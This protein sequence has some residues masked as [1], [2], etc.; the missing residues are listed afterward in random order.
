M[1]RSCGSASLI[2]SNE[3]SIKLTLTAGYFISRRQLT[4]L[5]PSCDFYF[6]EAEEQQATN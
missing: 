5:T 1:L 3:A 6:S 2:N 4:A